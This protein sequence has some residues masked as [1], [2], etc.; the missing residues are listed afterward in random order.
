MELRDI[1]VISSRNITWALGFDME[2][3]GWRGVIGGRAF[4][5]NCLL[6]PVEV[7]RSIRAEVSAPPAAVCNS[8]GLIEGDRTELMPP[9]SQS[10][11]ALFSVLVRAGRIDK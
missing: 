8:T 6:Q 1:S 2:L 4:K 3:W 11:A 9:V 10:L 7:A 5:V